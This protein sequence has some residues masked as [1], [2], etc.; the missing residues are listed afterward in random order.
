MNIKYASD[1]AGLLSLGV[2]K[3]SCKPGKTAAQ[4][5]TPRYGTGTQT[6]GAGTGLTCTRNA[7][8]L[9]K[10]CMIVCAQWQP[11]QVASQDF[12]ALANHGMAVENRFGCGSQH[13]YCLP[14]SVAAACKV[15]QLLRSHLA[16]Q[17]DL[18]YCDGGLPAF[19]LQKAHADSGIMRQHCCTHTCSEKCPAVLPPVSKHGPAW[20]LAKLQQAAC[21]HTDTHCCCCISEATL[22]EPPESLTRKDVSLHPPYVYNSSTVQLTSFSMLRQTV[23]DG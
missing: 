21:R 15:E 16:S 9:K 12:A 11:T 6:Q 10:P 3:S 19:I 8:R 7:I 13:N 1:C 5:S 14:S 18:L 22:H 20:T 17:Q 4:H 23:P 2:S